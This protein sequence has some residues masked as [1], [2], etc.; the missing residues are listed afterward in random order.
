[1]R[2]AIP[3]YMPT[4]SLVASDPALNRSD[5]YMDRPRHDSKLAATLSM[6]TLPSPPSAIQMQGMPR[7]PPPPYHNQ[8][9]PT[10]H[11]PLRPSHPSIRPHSIRPSSTS[12]TSTTPLYPPPQLDLSN[13]FSQA[14]ITS[15]HPS[16]AIYPYPDYTKDTDIPSMPPIDTVTSVYGGSATSVTSGVVTQKRGR[17]GD[18]KSDEDVG[19]DMMVKRRRNTEA[20]RR[21]RQKKMLKLTD[22]ENFAKRLETQNSKLTVKVAVLENEKVSLLTRQRDLMARIGELER[23]LEEAHKGLVTLNSA[24]AAVGVKLGKEGD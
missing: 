4:T 12:P 15:F 5:E 21:S 9:R 19:E 3:F 6:E 23:Q 16:T 13:T 14:A 17:S 22:L 20:A 24:M 7:P 11:Q 18:E 10:S 1:M 2:N 8:V